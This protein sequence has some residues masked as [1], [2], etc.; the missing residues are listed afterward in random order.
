[1]TKPNV[2]IHIGYP[3]SASTSLQENLFKKHPGIHYLDSPCILVNRKHIVVPKTLKFSTSKV[4]LL[5]SEGILWDLDWKKKINTLA[6]LY[7]NAKIIIVIRRQQ[8]ILKSY[9]N[10]FAGEPVID[11]KSQRKF[12]PFSEWIDLH[13]SYSK[14]TFLSNLYYDKVVNECKKKF[15]AKNIN[16]LLFEELGNNL[17]EFSKSLS[18]IL[19]INPV[20]TNKLLELSSKNPSCGLNELR[21][22]IRRIYPKLHPRK[23]LPSFLF[24]KIARIL[25][26]LTKGIKP[27]KLK[28]TTK[29][30]LRLN[31]LYK[32]SNI[33][34]QKGTGLP[35]KKYG[36]FI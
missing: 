4:N 12:I 16:I 1:M 6:R 27:K 29:Q 14:R 34:L 30:R 17:S 25:F 8:D 26:I 7:P 18:N 28:Y 35:L 24:L 5:S 13:M 32:Q 20:L 36:Y 2:Y 19:C 33:R 21:K 9:Y 22:I 31:A 15:G 3:K 11:D 23:I 10:H